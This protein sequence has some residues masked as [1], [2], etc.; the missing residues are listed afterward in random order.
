MLFQCALKLDRAFL[1]VSP[2]CADVRY[3]NRV[4]VCGSQP[5]TAKQP[6]SHGR[7]VTLGLPQGTV[8][9]ASPIADPHSATHTATA[10]A[11]VWVRED[12][13]VRPPS[14]IVHTGTRGAAHKKKVRGG[15]FV[16]VVTRFHV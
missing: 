4:C 12:E 16:I 3:C 13:P 5:A 10:A 2:L 9:P 15:V 11:D 8:R 7:S 1:C 6:T 14:P